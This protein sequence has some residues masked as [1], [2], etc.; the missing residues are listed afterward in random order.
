MKSKRQRR[1][2][3]GAVFVEALIVIS[4]FVTFL[5]GIVYF[6]ELY[7]TKMT[8]QR[9]ARA[10]SLAHA[11]A[12]CKSDVNATLKA[13]LPKEQTL[14][15]TSAKDGP[16]PTDPQLPSSSES[17]GNM[18]GKVA[19]R[20]GGTILN[21][22]GSVAISGSASAT[23]KPGMFQAETGYRGTVVSASYVSCGDELTNEQYSAIAG[24][25][26]SLLGL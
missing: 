3:R 6:R 8:G 26:P 16:R 1:R 19:E 25:I 17:G 20:R 18:M 24:Q 21:E 15:Q 7:L 12:A 2:T 14:R 11:M 22:V 5:L 4:V 10:G 23:S 9:L 13:D